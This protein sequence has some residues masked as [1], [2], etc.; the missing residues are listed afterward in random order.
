M[1]AEGFGGGST[2]R[3]VRAEYL[4]R[5]LDV[6]VALI[7]VVPFLPSLVGRFVWDDDENFVGNAD[8]GGLSWSGLRWAWMTYQGAVYQPFGWLLLEAEHS[9]WGMDPRGYH[10]VSMAL[11]ALNAVVLYRLVA[12]LLHRLLPDAARRDGPALHAGAAGA[13]ALFA[14]HPLRAEPVAW[15]SCQSYLPSILLAMLATLAYLR[16]HPPGGP[17]QTL[18]I[19]TSWLLGVAAMLFK[20]AA[21]SLPAVLLILDIYPLGRLGPG[22]WRDRRVWAEKLAFALPAAVFSGLAVLARASHRSIVG[23]AQFGPGER[24]AVALHG[25]VSYVA[26]TVWPFRLAAVYERPDSISLL[27]WPF[28]GAAAAVLAIS[29]GLVLARLRY[30]WRGPLAAWTAYLVILAPHLGLV[31]SGDHIAADRYCYLASVPLFVVV[32]WGL[33]RMIRAARGRPAVGA[34]SAGIAAALLL[35]LGSLS[36]AQSRTWRDADHLWS[37]ALAVSDRPSAGMLGN[38]GIAR[39]AEGKPD[40]AE[41]LFRRALAVNAADPNVHYCLGLLLQRQGKAA[42]AEGHFARALPH[43]LPGTPRRANA[44]VQLGL[45]LARRGQ[46]GSAVAHLNEAAEIKPN[47]PVV[48]YNLGLALLRMGRFAQSR[49]HLEAAVR[50]NPRDI[51]GRLALSRALNEL[52]RLD[53]ASAQL[54][55]AIR[56]RP[57]STDARFNL[58]LVLMARGRLDEAAA[59]FREVL[60]LRPDDDGA[61]RALERTR[62]RGGP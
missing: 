27:A 5:A 9:C 24:V 19:V 38:L 61:R 45:S 8:F 3:S 23:T 12:E 37:H 49:A 17:R 48:R 53:E 39:V 10:A 32:G 21:V 29:A 15:I 47:D 33:C 13:A 30:G 11:H 36:W 59:Q 35:G 43:F 44:A 54:E 20:A 60:R 42:E 28:S 2:L 51:A 50:R 55:E 62:A 58:G 40:E 46:L 18:W 4:K 7:A 41:A 34:L 6:V 25:V 52:G 14:A 56:I 57:D 26:E 31:P 1:M 16:A 22:R